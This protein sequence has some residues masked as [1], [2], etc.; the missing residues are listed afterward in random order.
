MVL[1]GDLRPWGAL[2]TRWAEGSGG[3]LFQCDKQGWRKILQGLRRC[4]RLG[5]LRALTWRSQLPREH[6]AMFVT[7]VIIKIGVGLP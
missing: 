3:E 4:L 1:P 7:S 2:A 6:W 5:Q